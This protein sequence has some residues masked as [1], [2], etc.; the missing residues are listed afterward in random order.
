MI[1]PLT[2]FLIWVLEPHLRWHMVNQ[3]LVSLVHREVKRLEVQAKVA[4]S[5]GERKESMQS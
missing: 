3:S 2:H 5:E 4:I 1:L